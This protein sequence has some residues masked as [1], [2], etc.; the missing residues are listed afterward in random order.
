M[1]CSK[2]IAVPINGV[3]VFRA[4]ESMSRSSP[5]SLLRVPELLLSP[6][7][8]YPRRLLA[9]SLLPIHNGY[10]DAI[11]LNISLSTSSIRVRLI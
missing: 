9:L 3:G 2:R 1:A 7:S 6:L 10:D 8:S 4:G 11:F 5:R